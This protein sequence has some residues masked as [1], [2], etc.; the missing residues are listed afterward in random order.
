M[1]TI[2]RRLPL[3]LIICCLVLTAWGQ[4][5]ELPTT[6]PTVPATDVVAPVTPPPVIPPYVAPDL[7]AVLKGDAPVRILRTQ[8]T[9]L[10]WKGDGTVR[11]VPLGGEPLYTAKPGEMVGLVRESSGQSCWLRQNGQ[12]FCA[13]PTVLRLES[14][15][16]IKLWT[17]SPDAWTSYSTPLVIT[18]LPDGKFSVA[19][20]LPLE[21]YLRGVLPAEMPA[22]FH[23]QALRAQAIIART[24][25]LTK[26]GRHAVEGADLCD[27]VHC[28][29]SL[30][31]KRT[32]ATDEAVRVTRGLVLM[33]GH[34]L[35]TTYYHAC[36][37][38][39]TD[40]AGYVW[41]PEFARSYLVGGTDF[42]GMVS[43]ATIIHAL[44]RED[45]YC[46]RAPVHR[47]EKI[48][49]PAEINALVARNLTAVSDDPTVKI[50]RVT[51]MSVEERTPFGRVASLRVEGDGASVLVYG[52]KVRWLFGSGGPGADGLWST[53]FDLTVERTPTGD[54]V[55]YIVRGAG[56]GHGLGLCQWGAD[57]RARAG[58][59][60]RE[61]LK[62]YYPGTRLSDE[63][64]TP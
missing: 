58:Q 63:P 33:D 41:G 7:Q 23:V 55:R 32:A 37:G 16:P 34:K 47:W 24:Y 3:L 42:A 4:R 17:P 20:E 2:L 8:Q 1:T 18:P 19:Q 30:D 9:M 38:G 14:N 29:V 15:T 43:G 5:A 26:L 22:S 50:T 57:G 45:A 39:V 54:I 10:A 56:R 28:Q 12:N 53:L 31:S 27:T 44:T 49:T 51:S 25:T 64:G 48:F 59:T 11:A 62:A 46:K 35:A 40:D 60:A 6:P 13:V 21:E 36:C 52:D 61:I